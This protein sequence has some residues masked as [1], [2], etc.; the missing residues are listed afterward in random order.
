MAQNKNNIN[1]TEILLQCMG[2]ADPMLEMLKWLCDQLMEA[3]L[4]DRIGADKHERSDIRSSYRC[5]Y[6]PRRLDT[7]MGTM[8]L[9]IPKVRR[10]GYIPFFITERKRSEAALIGT[11]QE[12]FIQGVSTRKME[13]LAQSL[14][15]ANISRSQ[16]SEITKGLNEQVSEFRNRSLAEH[17]YP[18]IWVDAL[19]EKV[20]FDGH[21]ISMAVMVVSGVNEEGSREILAIEP[22]VE[23]SKDGYNELFKSLRTRGMRNPL[24]VIS[25]AHAGLTAAIRESFPGTSWQRCKVH[26]MRNILAHVTQQTKDIFAKELK[27]IWHAPDETTAKNRARGMI[28][29]YGKRFPQ[30]MTILEEGLQDSLSCYAYTELDQRKIST[31]N[32]L[33]R[34]NREIR[35]RS[36]VVGIFPN[37]ESYIRLITMY[38]IEYTEDWS[39]SQAYLSRQSIQ[40][41]LAKAA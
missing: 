9:L 31:T 6:R 26:F 7:R 15:I 8:Y 4:S 21:V 33:E 39:T 36:R 24:L 18:V 41:V 19:Y 35:R 25:D 34:L 12:A 11:I 37:P 30:A 27:E 32:M 38:M 40:S 16:V 28:Q 5:G 10:G 1:L 29:R 20:R 3:E 13:K 14:G 23:E 17:R 22:M 2:K